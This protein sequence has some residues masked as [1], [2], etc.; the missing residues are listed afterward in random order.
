M[1]ALIVHDFESAERN[2]STAQSSMA[3]LLERENWPKCSQ[4]KEAQ[5]VDRN[6]SMQEYKL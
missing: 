1:Q 5:F 3:T 4:D 2:I 6:A